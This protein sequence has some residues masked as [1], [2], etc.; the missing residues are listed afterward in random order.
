MLP[1]QITGFLI[2]AIDWALALILLWI[3]FKMIAA[4][5]GL[6]IPISLSLGVLFGAL[7]TGVGASLLF[8]PPSKNDPQQ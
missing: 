1:F 3:G 2:L 8:N 5:L 7:A 6:H 4:P